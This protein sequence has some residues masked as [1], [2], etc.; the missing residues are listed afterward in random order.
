MLNCLIFS[1]L[2]FIAVSFNLEF[3][4]LP[5]F[6][7]RQTEPKPV[8]LPLHHRTILFASFRKSGAKIEHF[9]YSCKLLAFFS[10]KLNLK[11]TFCEEAPTQ[12]PINF[13]F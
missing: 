10:R 9:I 1:N 2:W 13:S 12:S 7:P 3:V 5:G 11:G 4:V 8:V 6:E